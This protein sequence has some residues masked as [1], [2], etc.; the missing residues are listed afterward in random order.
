VWAANEFQSR[1]VVSEFRFQISDFDFLHSA[2]RI[3]NFP[4]VAAVSAAYLS[5]RNSAISNSP[6]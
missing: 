5:N 2:F 6:F 4:V 3:P 1:R